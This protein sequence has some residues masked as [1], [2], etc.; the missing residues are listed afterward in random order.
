[1][2]ACIE[3][4][5]RVAAEM[6]MELGKQVGYRVGGTKMT[7]SETIIEFVTDGFLAME[8]YHGKDRNILAK[9][10]STIIIDEAHERS[11]DTDVLLAL[12]RQLI[13][14]PDNDL[15]LIIMSA[16]INAASFLNHFPGSTA[17]HVAGGTPHVIQQKYLKKAASNYPSSIGQTIEHIVTGNF[18]G[19]ILVF[20]PGEEEISMLTRSLR[21][22][23]DQ[24][25][26]VVYQ[27]YDG[28]TQQD[29]EAVLTSHT[30]TPPTYTR[31][32]LATN[33]AETSLTVENVVHVI[34]SGLEK[35]DVYD[36]ITKCEEL[37]LTAVS[38]GSAD[39]RKG[40]VGRTR[41]GICWRMYTEL[42]YEMMPDHHP[43]PI[44]RSRLARV[45]LGLRNARPD[46]FL[47]DIPFLDAPPFDFICDG[48]EELW[49]MGMVDVKLRVTPFGE[50][51]LERPCDLELAGMLVEGDRVG[52][53]EE[54]LCLAS[55]LMRRRPASVLFDHAI[56]QY[57][58]TYG[59][60]MAYIHAMLHENQDLRAGRP[61]SEEARNKENLRRRL[62]PSQVYP[63]PSTL[64]DSRINDICRTIICGLPY[65]IAR[66]SFEDTYTDRR[67]GNQVQLSKR[68]LVYDH[69]YMNRKRNQDLQ[70]N[71]PEYLVYRQMTQIGTRA[72]ISGVL[73][74]TEADL[75]GAIKDFDP[76]YEP[77]NAEGDWD[78]NTRTETVQPGAQPA[79]YTSEW[80][81]ATMNPAAR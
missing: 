62:Q 8:A 54:M 44:T 80:M 4:A 21:T 23:A 25:R 24:L 65:R 27:L 15:K 61:N 16:T 41:A 46:L 48:Y 52:L 26:L 9:R 14:D 55:V 29:K 22:V 79:W 5:R 7:S 10:Y 58:S 45:I 67:T 13:D 17:V 70:P 57:L 72:I 47:R 1:M 76:N 43:V 31:V 19:D 81:T 77:P 63:P 35:V 18:G 66:H 39:Q 34:D 20:L 60:L 30:R 33:I 38:K 69:A 28:M 56:D 74:V 51:A 71:F 37:R 11:L 53:A 78:W 36:P 49:I 2:V 12:L 75:R 59:D 6:D 3:S 64:R 73:V 68:S 42:S 40:R 50:E 32:I